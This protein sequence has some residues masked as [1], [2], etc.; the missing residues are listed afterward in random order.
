MFC[1]VFVLGFGAISAALCCPNKYSEIFM[2]IAKL[3]LVA[4]M[5]MGTV[6]F[7]SASAITNGTS[8]I[9]ECPPQQPNACPLPAGMKCPFN[10]PYYVLMPS[11]GCE[12]SATPPQ[13]NQPGTGTGPGGKKICMA[14]PVQ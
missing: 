5:S 1:I 11:G 2:K 6:P 14:P 7:S 13:S 10:A 12:C 8:P 3:T 4:L 9:G